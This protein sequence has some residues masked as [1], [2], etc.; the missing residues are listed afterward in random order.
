M[1]VRFRE[2]RNNVMIMIGIFVIAIVFMGVLIGNGGCVDET[3]VIKVLESQGFH[4][5]V[6]TG[7]K[8]FRGDVFCTGFSAYGP[9]G[10]KVSG[11]VTRGWYKGST[12][13]FD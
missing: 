3:G 8:P 2:S 13:R 5:I 9:T 11:V 1:S 4:N 12:I 6:I 10:K 7:W